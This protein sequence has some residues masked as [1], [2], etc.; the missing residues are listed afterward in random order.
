M[1]DQNLDLKLTRASDDTWQLTFANDAE[2]R[3]FQAFTIQILLQ[4]EAGAS[5]N[6]MP[7]AETTGDAFD[8]IATE[9]ANDRVL[10]LAS[11][12][13][14]LQQSIAAGVLTDLVVHQE[15]TVDDESLVDIARWLSRK[16]VMLLRSE[17]DGTIEA[18]CGLWSETFLD[19]AIG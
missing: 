3:S 5:F 11:M 15:A 16:R 13:H 6:E 10:E 4:I 8:A 2:T 17:R 19:A 14:G 12:S 7:H 1:E 9:V 18:L